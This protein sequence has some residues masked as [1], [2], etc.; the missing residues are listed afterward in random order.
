MEYSFYR[1]RLVNHTFQA[2]VTWICRHLP[3]IG[4]SKEKMDREQ[5]MLY[6][7]PGNVL[8]TRL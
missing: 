3:S 7:L 6:V 1:M 8:L 2:I 5:V 4:G